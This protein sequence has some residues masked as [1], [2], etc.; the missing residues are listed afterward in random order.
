[1]LEV[2]ELAS[3]IK[4]LLSRVFGRKYPDLYDAVKS[5]AEKRGL[6]P[7]HVIASAVAAYLSAD[8]EGKEELEEAMKSL[9]AKRGGSGGMNLQQFK[10]YMDAFVDA[11]VRIQEAGQ[12]LVK[13]MIVNELRGT[14]ETIEEIK[15]IGSESGGQGTIEDL[16]AA[17]LINRILGGYGISLPSKNIPARRTGKGKV[18]KLE[19]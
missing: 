18:E 19:E 7:E 8:E 10:A 15:K 2:R 1:M 5:Y 13:G 6:K 4:R 9:A 14:I 11:M 3:K 12:K 17:A 16:L